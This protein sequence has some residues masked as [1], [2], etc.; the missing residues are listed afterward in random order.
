MATLLK[1]RNGNLFANEYYATD[2]D[3]MVARDRWEARGDGRTAQLPD[4]PKFDPN[5]MRHLKGEK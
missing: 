2:W 5:F 4:A 1:Y 3:A